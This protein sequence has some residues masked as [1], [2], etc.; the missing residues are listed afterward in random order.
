[1]CVCVCVCGGG[2]ARARACA[3]FAIWLF[4]KHYVTKHSQTFDGP[5]SR[6]HYYMRRTALFAVNK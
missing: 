3:I 4:I 2:C 5:E 1:M 6:E